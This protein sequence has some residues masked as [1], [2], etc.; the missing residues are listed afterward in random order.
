MGTSV[1]YKTG[2]YYAWIIDTE[3]NNKAIFNKKYT[4]S[5]PKQFYETNYGLR[6]ETGRI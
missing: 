3:D 1:D 5:S 4:E 2:I 6:K